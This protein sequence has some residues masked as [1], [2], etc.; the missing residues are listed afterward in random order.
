MRQT[1]NI[2]C[3][4]KVSLTVLVDN[5]ANLIVESTDTVKHF[6]E[7]PLLAEHGFSVFIQVNDAEQQILWDAG[8]SKVALIENMHRMK[9]DPKMISSIALSHGHM[10]HYAAMTELLNEMN[11]APEDKEWGETVTK[12]EID[13]TVEYIKSTKPTY[14]I[15]SHC[16]GFQAIG[17]F[18]QEMPDEFIEGIVGATYML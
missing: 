12:D 1:D 10:D 16:T 9:I 18:A 2:D 13:K 5:K 8:V 11:L 3:V 6:T 14:I 7:K 15:P 4:D 17:Q